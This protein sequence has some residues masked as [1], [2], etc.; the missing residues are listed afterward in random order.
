MLKPVDFLVNLPNIYSTEFEFLIYQITNPILINT[1][2]APFQTNEN[3]SLFLITFIDKKTIPITKSKITEMKLVLLP[4][5]TIKYKT[6][7]KDTINKIKEI[8]FILL[9]LLPIIFFS[10]INNTYDN[11]TPYTV[12]VVT[13]KVFGLLKIP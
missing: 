4:D 9:L 8:N 7:N 3:T 2:G 6:N 13:P 12:V 10:I 5:I 11:M 1:K